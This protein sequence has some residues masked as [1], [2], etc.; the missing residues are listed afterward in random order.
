MVLLSRLGGALVPPPGAFPQAS[1][2][3]R[4]G[5]VTAL[6]AAL[7]GS[8]MPSSLRNPVD[9]TPGVHTRA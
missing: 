8:L 9:S 4:T 2:R 5:S 1:A 6:A 7:R 3:L